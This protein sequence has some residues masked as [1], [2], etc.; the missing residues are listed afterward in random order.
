MEV[1]TQREL[2]GHGGRVFDCGLHGR[3][4]LLATASEDGTA[5]VWD[6]AGG[7]CVGVL[8]GH[9]DEVL[10][11]AWAPKVV[12]ESCGAPLL[13]TAGADGETRLWRGGG[14]C[15]ASGGSGCEPRL[16]HTLVPNVAPGGEVEQVYG[17]AWTRCGDSHGA[18]LLTA[19]G[20][21]VALWDAA[22]GCAARSWR[23]DGS[24]RGAAKR[25]GDCFVFDVSPFADAEADPASHAPPCETLVACAVSDGTVRVHDVRAPE[26]Q[27]VLTATGS[28]ARLTAVDW[29]RSGAATA[30]CACAGDGDIHV[31][32]ARTWRATLKLRGAHAQPAY[33]AAWRPGLDAGGAE[34]FLSW[35][36]DGCLGFWDTRDDAKATAP[37]PWKDKD[38]APKPV[39]A[40]PA[41]KARA[42]TALVPIFDDDGARVP[43]FHCAFDPKGDFIVACGGGGGGK[44]APRREFE[45]SVF[46]LD[47]AGGDGDGDGDDGRSPKKARRADSADDEAEE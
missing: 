29:Q 32:D 10:R 36:C 5:R 24:G 16:L 42:A 20:D 7:A 18:W 9:V 46:V 45:P 39:A 8:R 35:S 22:K 11:V 30:L 37:C 31:W 2:V 15:W 44:H 6:L 25:D 26:P 38:G 21:A 43:L 41:A 1:H 28:G 4:P 19:Y 27:T 14:G 34:P 3:E 40:A 17:C 47:L 23:Y 12:E 13:A 33:G